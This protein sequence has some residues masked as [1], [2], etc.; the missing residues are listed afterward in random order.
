MCWRGRHRNCGGFDS[1][2][3]LHLEIELPDQPRHGYEIIKVLE[4]KTDGWYSP[5]PGIVY[6]TSARSAA[7]RRSMI[8]GGVPAGATTP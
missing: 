2:V 5:S 6:P 4:E 3:S 1:P 8:A 7:L